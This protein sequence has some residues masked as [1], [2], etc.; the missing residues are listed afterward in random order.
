[1]V[2]RPLVLGYH[3]C[4]LA[5]AQKIVS[6]EEKMWGSENPWDWLGHGTYF[7]EDSPARAL[8]WAEE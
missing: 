6:G 4:D 1:M 7:W 8:H 3:G 2:S 5:L